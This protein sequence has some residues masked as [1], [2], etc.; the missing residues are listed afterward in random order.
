MRKLHY[1]YQPRGQNLQ[2]ILL[3]ASI[4]STLNAYNV[5][6]KII[7]VTVLDEVR[8]LIY[9]ILQTVCTM[10]ENISKFNFTLHSYKWVNYN[11]NNYYFYYSILP[12]I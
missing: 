2:P 8:F 5:H 7:D 6:V 11:H 4:H 12:I 9:N 10:A 3:C 1:R